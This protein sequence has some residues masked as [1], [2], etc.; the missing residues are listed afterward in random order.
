MLVWRHSLPPVGSRRITGSGRRRGGGPA[1]GTRW[2]PARA[3]AA[4]Q[5]SG[6]WSPLLRDAR[7]P[8]T[9]TWPRWWALSR[10]KPVKRGVAAVEQPS[11]MRRGERTVRDAGAS[12]RPARCPAHPDASASRCP[13]REGT[14]RDRTPS[15]ATA[16]R[17]SGCWRRVVSGRPRPPERSV[18]R[19]PVIPG[20]PPDQVRGKLREGRGSTA[21]LRAGSPSLAALA[22][23]DAGA[24]RGKETTSTS[25]SPKTPAAS[26][27]DGA[28]SRLS[29]SMGSSFAARR[30]G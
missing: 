27:R 9:R 25:A 5:G 26:C 21:A 12:G 10:R 23:D 11:P 8:G 20:E 6:V 15:G 14:R 18:R 30:A 1:V 2:C 19:S 22:R 29:A 13:S 4:T 28:Y 16:P 3:A 17:G 7:P 24:P